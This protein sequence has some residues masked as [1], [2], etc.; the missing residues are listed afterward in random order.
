MK[1][2]SNYLQTPICLRASLLSLS[3]FLSQITRI[4]RKNEHLEIHIV[5]RKRYLRVSM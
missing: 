5:G 2:L 4:V 1:H 3:S